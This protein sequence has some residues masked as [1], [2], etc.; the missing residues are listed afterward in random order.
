MIKLNRMRQV[1]RKIKAELEA[2]R[3]EITKP[4][5]ELAGR[6]MDYV[7]E[8]LGRRQEKVGGKLLEDKGN[9]EN[10]ENKENQGVNLQRQLIVAE[11]GN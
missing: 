5:R 7:F 4:F 1:T 11:K 8:R 3:R 9:K 10:R 2:V 6:E